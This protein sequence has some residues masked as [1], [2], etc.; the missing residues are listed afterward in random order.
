MF[1]TTTLP[2][3]YCRFQ[4]QSD[5]S[6]QLSRQPIYGTRLNPFATQITNHAPQFILYSPM[7]AIVPNPLRARKRTEFTF[8]APCMREEAVTE[9]ISPF[10]IR[11]SCKSHLSPNHGQVSPLLVP[12][13]YDV[14]DVPRFRQTTRLHPS[15]YPQGDLSLASESVRMS[16]R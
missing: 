4:F 3:C 16:C 14:L 7:G 12:V 5:L 1:R 15:S 6:P 10:I 11:N 2:L 8:T 13:G 9:N